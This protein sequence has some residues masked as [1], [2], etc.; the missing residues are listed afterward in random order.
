MRPKTLAKFAELSEAIPT[1]AKPEKFKVASSGFVALNSPPSHQVLLLKQLIGPSSSNF[2]LITW[3]G[4][5]PKRILDHSGRIIA[6][7]AGQ[8]QEES[9]LE[10]VAQATTLLKEAGTQGKFNAS[11]MHHTRGQFPMLST[12]FAHGGGRAA[13]MNQA[14]SEETNANVV[15]ELVRDP[16]F[17]RVASV[18]YKCTQSMW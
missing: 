15:D 12:G 11:Q 18:Q 17:N 7:C 14:P 8:P 2:R 10:T 13:P 9:W 16:A 6:V 5:R 3:D 1:D 4:K